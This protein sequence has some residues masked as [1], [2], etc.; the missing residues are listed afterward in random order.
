MKDS[1]YYITSTL[2]NWKI[3]FIGGVYDGAN[4]LTARITKLDAD[5]IKNLVIFFNKDMVSTG[6]AEYSK[7]FSTKQHRHHLLFDKRDTLYHYYSSE[8]KENSSKTFIVGGYY[9]KSITHNSMTF[10]ERS[11]FRTH[12]DSLVKIKGNDLPKLPNN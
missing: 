8:I 2:S 11:F 9:F 6:I 1:P 7:E 5:T 4:T 3:N 10:E 12:R